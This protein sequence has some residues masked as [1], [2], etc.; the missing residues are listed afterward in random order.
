MANVTTIQAPKP[1]VIRFYELTCGAEYRNLSVLKAG[2]M[3]RCPVH[4]SLGHKIVKKLRKTETV[5][6]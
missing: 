4:T 2:T 3:V 6:V 1:E 5:E